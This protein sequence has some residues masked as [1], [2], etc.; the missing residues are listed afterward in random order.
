MYA[1]V[2]NGDITNKRLLSAKEGSEYTSLGANS[3]RKWA[4][5]I[6][7]MRRVG[8]RVLFDKKVIDAALDR[9]NAE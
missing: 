8:T 3:F 6:G 7:A 5:N 9:V 4:E 2:V 1:R